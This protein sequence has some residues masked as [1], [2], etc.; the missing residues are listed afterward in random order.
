MLTMPNGPTYS[1]VFLI[2]HFLE[3]SAALH[4]EKI[5]LIHEDTRTTFGELDAKSNQLANLLVSEGI[6]KGDRVI[7]LLE[8]SIEYVISYYGVLKAGGAVVSLSTGL[9]PASVASFIMELQ[10]GFIITSF[11]FERVIAAALKSD[12]LPRLII[13]NSKIKWDS[14]KGEVLPWESALSRMSAENPRISVPE[15]SLAGIIFTSGSMGKP[16]GV[17]LSHRNIVSNTDSIC[18]ALVLREDDIQMVV[19]PFFYVMGKSLLN[20]LFSVG[21]TIV[22][23]NKFAFPATVINQMIEEKV[24]IFSGVPSTYSYLLHRSPLKK[25]RDRLD[26]LRLV[27]QAGGHMAKSVKKALREALPEQTRI[28][29]MYG[30]TE[31]SARITCL[32]PDLFEEKIDSIGRAIPGVTLR[33]LDRMGRDVSQGAKGELVARGPNIMMGYWNDPA[34]TRK[35]LDENGY[36]TGDIGFQDKDGFFFVDGRRDNLVKVG[37]HRINPREVEDAIMATEMAVDVAVVGLADALLGSKLAALVVPLNGDTTTEKIM[38]RCAAILPRHKLPSEIKFV[39][40]L[41]VTSNGK[42]NRNGCLQV[43][44]DAC[45]EIQ[46]A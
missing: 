29:I 37:G 39:K 23:N 27:T 45:R 41:P 12:C 6:Q 46:T 24:T 25:S 28:C 10:P 36:H 4:P 42:V 22:L 2:H 26:R 14:Y 31:A 38:A 16:K 15:S 17:M 7:I 34:S 44:G 9:K 3:K 21:G 19:L 8:N 33:I 13:R 30:A 11:K 32:D 35:A 20:T 5:A 1:P 18:R 40:S 43:F